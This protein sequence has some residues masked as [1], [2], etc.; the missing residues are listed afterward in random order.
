MS[1]SA[2]EKNWAVKRREEQYRKSETEEL[3]F[4]TVLDSRINSWESWFILNLQKI[5]TNQYYESVSLNAGNNS[6]I[7]E[8]MTLQDD[9]YI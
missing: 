6:T 4:A 8:S 7:R 1:K 3:L 2:E 5:N 9:N